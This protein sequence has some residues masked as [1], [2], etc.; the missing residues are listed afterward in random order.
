M[1]VTETWRF[2]LCPVKARTFTSEFHH[3]LPL[4]TFCFFDYN[5]SDMNYDTRVVSMSRLFWGFY[6]CS[7]VYEFLSLSLLLLFLYNNRLYINE[8]EILDFLVFEINKDKVYSFI[9][10]MTCSPKKNQEHH[11]SVGIELGNTASAGINGGV[12]IKRSNNNEIFSGPVNNSFW[13]V[14]GQER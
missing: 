10:L 3:Q 6:R 12:T 2:H 1:A 13:N 14:C 5:V 8:Y 4:S 11:P 9:L 7:S